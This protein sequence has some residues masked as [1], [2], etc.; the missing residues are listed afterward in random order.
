MSFLGEV[1][2]DE[3]FGPFTAFR[4]TFGFIPN[5]L[6]AQTLLPRVIEAQIKLEELCVC[7]M[8]SD[9]P[10]TEGTNP[11]KRLQLIDRTL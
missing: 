9:F 4:E 5:L 6:Y 2:L 3:K 10:S 8:E 1:R 11:S 7:R